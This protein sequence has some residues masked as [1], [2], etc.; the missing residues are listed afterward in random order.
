MGYGSTR[1]NVQRFTA[2]VRQTRVEPPVLQLQHLAPRRDVAPQV[3][4][5][6]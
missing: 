3:A 4:F 6:I 1:F 2:A 5:E